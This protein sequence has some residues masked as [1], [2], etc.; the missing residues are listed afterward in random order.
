MDKINQIWPSWHTVELIGRGGFG[1]VYKA[2][3][4]L[5]GEVFYSAVKVI[6]IP[7]DEQDVREMLAEGHTSQSIRY[8]YESAAK[9][10]LNE[11]KV[12]DALKSAGN[13][14]N[15][16]DFDIREREDTIGWEV[17]IRME[18][19]EN[20]DAYRARR[21]MSASDVAKL[22]AD[23]CRA[24][25][26]CEKS[27]IIHRDIKP[28]NIFVDRYGV[29]KLGD[30]GIARQMEKTQSTL[31]Q[32]GTEL[33]MAPEVRFGKSGSSY[34][35]DIYSLGLVMYRLLNKNRMPFEP[36]EQEMLTYRDRE[37]AVERRLKGER[38][39]DP[40]QADKSLSDIIRKACEYDAKRRYQS[41]GEMK[42]ELTA[43]LKGEQQEHSDGGLGEEKEENPREQERGGYDGDETIAFFSRQ[44]ERKDGFYHYSYKKSGNQDGFYHYSFKQDGRSGEQAAKKNGESQGE[45]YRRPWH[46]PTD[47]V[48]PLHLFRAEATAGLSRTIDQMDGKK[49]QLQIPK[50]IDEGKYL[51]IRVTLYQGSII[52]RTEVHYYAICFTPENAGEGMPADEADIL[53]ALEQAPGNLE[54]WMRLGLSRKQRKMPE[55]AESCYRKILEADGNYIQAYIGIGDLYY[56]KEDH[57]TAARWYD[58]ALARAETGIRH[59]SVDEYGTLYIRY[60]VSAGKCGDSK[61]SGKLLDEAVKKNLLL[62]SDADR[63]CE[64][65]GIAKK[66]KGIFGRWK[67]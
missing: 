40:V 43:Y 63:I 37:Q 58:M 59:I 21:A 17:Y 31:S 23:L 50:G 5:Q 34:N 46:K 36:T 20:L 42:E 35:V 33:Y 52:E 32:K 4:E 7:K 61:K 19:L 12:L 22:G 14:M 39:P 6:Q 48:K 65:Y 2:K 67:K 28:K 11:I 24:L 47:I 55:D 30:F 49:I 9:D 29:Y 3:R 57:E 53:R 26:C 8:Y 45:S 60:A 16:E 41:A 51:R 56:E 62:Q 25:E 10:L 27:H 13:V 38:L 15:I 18:L 54:L 66:Q 1:E 64:E 44:E